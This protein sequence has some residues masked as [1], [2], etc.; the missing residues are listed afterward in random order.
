MLPR[1][2]ALTLK[3][4]LNKPICRDFRPPWRKQG[5][6]ERL[7]QPKPLERIRL[8][9][10]N[11]VHPAGPT[12]LHTKGEEH[13]FP[14]DLDFKLVTPEDERVGLVLTGLHPSTNIKTVV[15]YLKKR[16]ALRHCWVRKYFS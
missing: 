13:V 8:E 9:P 16:I 12:N 1:R 14:V 7:P 2:P 15:D 5:Y 10:G 4:R 6:L 3:V 11:V